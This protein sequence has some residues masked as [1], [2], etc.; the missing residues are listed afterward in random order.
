MLASSW[1]VRV[2][3]KHHS[4]ESQRRKCRC[5]SS[6]KDDE[7]CQQLPSLEQLYR[8]YG[9]QVYSIALNVLESPEDAEDV[10]QEVFLKVSSKAD[11]FR[12]EAAIGTWLYRVTVNTSLNW[13]RSRRRRRIREEDWSQKSRLSR[14][15]PDNPEGFAE[16]KRKL[17]SLRAAMRELDDTYRLPVILHDIE[18]LSYEEV[19]DILSI[20]PGTVGS[21]LSRARKKLMESLEAMED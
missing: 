5:T 6:Q 12:G 18:G 10:T 15:A 21:R 8:Q 14:P 16:Q 17:Q 1:R 11:A 3:V 19:A 4:Q 13:Q 7:R 9:D 2:K 20:K